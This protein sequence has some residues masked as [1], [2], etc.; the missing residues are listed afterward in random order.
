MRNPLAM[1]LEYFTSAITFY[2]N[3]VRCTPLRGELALEESFKLG[4]ELPVQR[5]YD[6]SKVEHQLKQI[7]TEIYLYRGI[8]VPYVILTNEEEL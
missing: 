1:A 8:F 6:R 7:Q 4:V 3:D 5:T 2:F